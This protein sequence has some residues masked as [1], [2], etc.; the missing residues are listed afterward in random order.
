MPENAIEAL[1]LG[2]AVAL[3]GMILVGAFLPK[4]AAL[5]KLVAG[6]AARER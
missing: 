3:I 6:K 2:L 5:W 4:L 1:T